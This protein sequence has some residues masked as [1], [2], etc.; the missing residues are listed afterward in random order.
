M[1]ISDL[2][3]WLAGYRDAVCPAEYAAEI[4]NT[5]MKNGIDSR[6]MRRCGDGKLRFSMTDSEY[7]KLIRLLPEEVVVTEQRHGLPYL[8]YRYRKR[9]GIPVGLV[10]FAVLVKLS[11]LYVWDITVSGNERLSDEEIISSLG[12]LGFGIGTKIP[13]VDFYSICHRLVLENDG[14]SWVSVNMIGTT[15]RVEVIELRAKEDINDDGNGTPTNLVAACDGK[16]VRVETAS[17]RTEVRA[18]ES[19]KKGQLLVNGVLEI[20]KEGER[21]YLPVRSRARVYAETEVRLEAVI[22]FETVEKT[23]I[24]RKNLSKSINFFGKTIKLKENSGILP[25]GCDIIE[26]K[27]RLVLFEGGRLTGGIALPVSIVTGYCEEYRTEKVILT[28]DEAL[29]RAEREMT[30]MFSSVLSGAEILSVSS[31]HFAADGEMHLVRTVVCVMNIAEEV[32]IGISRGSER[33]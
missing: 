25:D 15:A 5:V 28:E 11:T 22:P 3:D 12:D 7:G 1:L 2:L 24:G 29:M 18:G 16:I 23:F 33:Q 20:G 4:C 8:V 13:S 14:I 21:G 10:I 19:V 27:R 26:D 32:P 17:G 30:D 6:G 31:E 9:I